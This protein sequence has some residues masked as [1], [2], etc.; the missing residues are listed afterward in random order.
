MITEKTFISSCQSFWKEI[1]PMLSQF[2]RRQNLKMERFR[3]PFDTTSDDDRG[4]IGELVFRLFCA[5]NEKSCR[6]MDLEEID[7]RNCVDE[8]IKFIWRFRAFSRQPKLYASELGIDEARDLASRLLEF[9][10]SEKVSLQTWPKFS[11]CG[12][13]D[14]VEG[15]VLGG[16]T[17][18]EIKCGQSKIKGQDI[19]QLLC[20]L[21][22]NY[23][24]NEYQIDRICL[25]NPRTGLVFRCT[26]DSL[27]HGISGTTTPVLL[28]EILE[29]VTQPRWNL[30]G[31]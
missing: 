25:V 12:W 5:C 23:A 10:N 18:Y 30:E 17:L 6:N 24:S 15:D 9:L 13:L 3:T 20:Y 28:G 4:L 1:A 21:A 14:T 2:V 7:I 11:G 8:S 22:L 19:K 27:C 31:M 29:F 26:V 16:S